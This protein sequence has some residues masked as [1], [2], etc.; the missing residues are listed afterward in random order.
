M[1][2]EFLINTTTAGD[3]E[4]PAVAALGGTQF[5]AVWSDRASG[6]IKGQL[7]GVNG[8]KSSGEFTVN[9]PGKIG[10][11][12]T[13]PAVIETDL[14]FVVAWIEQEPSATPQL[15]LRTFDADSLSGPE[16]RISSAEV[17][18]LIR[19]VLARLPAGA[20]VVVW[21]DK[22]A[23]ERIRV[24]RFGADGAKV[25]PELRANTVAGLHRVPM[26]AALTNGNIVVAWR[27]RL[28]GPLLVHLQIFN[29]SGPVGTEVT[30]ALDIT[31]AAMAPL[32]TGRFVIT[33]VRSALDGETGFD[34]TIA[35][36]NVF[37]PSGV[38]ANI[39]LAATTGTRIQSS[40]PTLAPLS[41]GRFLLAWT[42][43]ATASTAGT[44][45]MARMFS[46]KG[47]IG[48]AVKVNTLTGGSRFSLAAAATAG[49]AGETAF[50]AW[51]DDSAKG[52]DKAGRAIEGRVLT[53]PAAGF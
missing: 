9:F 8:A 10:T 22:R 50:F 23:N 4:Q 25:G 29:A 48:K 47:A 19:P 27:A 38:S 36:S 40:W 33:T 15:K 12:R 5:V 21:T 42:Q 31:E 49:P 18:P 6:T 26:V 37:E 3:Q 43:T 46:A 45:V 41:G 53:I 2:D 11:K 52:A 20:F 16:S 30:T 28:P 34:T 13:L 7:L 24:Q 1:A 14:G 44:N 51:N 17:E 32:D 35:Q 39:K